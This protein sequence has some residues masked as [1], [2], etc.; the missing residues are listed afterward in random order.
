MT[1]TNRKLFWAVLLALALAS[2]LAALWLFPRAM[3]LLQLNVSM[4]RDQAL[5]AAETLQTQ[6]FAELGT[7]RVVARFDHDANLQNYIELDGGGVNAFTGL[8]G[9]RFVAPYYWTVRRFAESQ[10]D[11][12]A[13]R[14]TPEGHAYGFT[15]K[16]PEKAPGATLTEAAA[17][18]LAETGARSLLGDALW[19]AYAPQSASQITRPGGR[20][21]HSFVYEHQSEQRGEARFRLKLEVAGDRLVDVTPYAFV[22]QAFGQRFAQLRS[23]NETIAKVANIAMVTLLGLGGLL[24]GWLWLARRGGLTWRPALLA[25]GVVGA[26]LAG[27]LLSNLPQNWFGYLTTDSASSFLLRNG[28]TAL[29]AGVGAMLMLGLVF[30]VA[31]GLSRQAFAQHPRVFSLWSVHAG[32]SPQA[33]G[34]TL[35]GYAW[36]GFELLLVVGFYLVARTQFGWWLP[37]ESLTDPNILSAWRPALGPIANALMAGTWEE[38]MFRAVPLAGAALIGQRI[39]W[40]RSSIAVALVLQALVFAGGHASYPGL[41]S[42]SRVVELFLPALVWGLIFL[43]FGLVPCIVMHFTFDLTLMS[44]PL[45]VATDSRLWLDRALVLLAG[46]FPLLMLARAR[47]KQGYFAELPQALRHGEAT[48][49]PQGIVQIGDAEAVGSIPAPVLAAPVQRPWWLGRTPLAVAAALGVLALLLW[50]APKVNTPPF[51]VDHAAAVMRAEGLLAERG[52]RLDADWKRLAIVRPVAAGDSKAVRFV[53]REAGPQVFAKLLGSTLLP[54]HWQVLFK[55][56]S[57]PVEERAEVWEVALTGQGEVLA[58]EHHLPEGRAGAKLD[59]AQAQALVTIYMADHEALAKRP[60]ELAS[61]Q[62]KELP[63]RRDWTFYWDDKQALDV[64]G[65]TS[66]LAVTVRGDELAAWQY[67]F[68][69][70]AW[71]REQ[72]QAESAKTPFRVVAGIAGAALLLLMLG[73]ALRQVVQGTLHWRQGLTWA[74]LF[75]VSGLAEY[76]LTFDHKAMGFNVAQ[77]WNTQLATGGALAATGYLLGAALWGLLAM[78]LHSQERPS[79]ASI[80]RDMARGLGLALVLQGI[81]SALHHFLP[82]NNPGLPGVGAWDSIQ[83]LLTTALRGPVG[84]VLPF[85]LAALTVGTVHFC[86]TRRRMVLIGSLA[87]VLLVSG[88]FA[89][90]SPSTG[91]TQFITALLVGLTAWALAQR[92]EVGVL[93]AMLAMAPIIDLP[94]L[95]A[96]PIANSGTHAALTCV[97]AVG[98]SWWTLR[99]GRSL[100]RD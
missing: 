12:L 29:G 89:S 82:D 67:V 5:A 14:F 86:H 44:L 77:D 34:R 27:A 62:E 43:R 39:G 45:F 9:R 28:A 71:E 15:R 53:W 97:L 75:L 3:P 48:A 93:M 57:G 81:N 63:A 69:P 99:Y 59:R 87:A 51:T 46:L 31:E 35:G 8:L 37:A 58:L 40:R 64:K 85:A 47:F 60:W 30:A 88:A 7:T 41:P 21:D 1:L 66:R 22:P 92:G 100:G 55:H 49:V 72:Q 52:V 25:G 2:A 10:E 4:S 56:A 19:V 83:P 70:E 26:L 73:T 79:H 23:G 50:P 78:R 32:A 42:Y 80:A 90:E 18:T 91:S 76:A 54:Q 16:V 65:G 95:L 11:E 36:T 24:G 38:A 33:L 13:V 68:V 94:R 98:L 84:V 17:R 61:V 20:V 96:M 74:A 6:R